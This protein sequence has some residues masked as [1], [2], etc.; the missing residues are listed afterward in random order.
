MD[1]GGPSMARVRPNGFG[2]LVDLDFLMHLKPSS[3]PI[4]ID[5]GNGNIISTNDTPYD[6]VMLI[7]NSNQEGHI[8]SKIEDLAELISLG[9]TIGGS[10][11]GAN[12]QSVM[13]NVVTMVNG[14]V[15]DVEN[16]KAW[17]T[18]MG[19][20]EIYFDGNKL[21]NIYAEKVINQLIHNI[22]N[23]CSDNNNIANTWI[24]SPEVMIRENNGQDNV[25]DRLLDAA[26]RVAFFDVNDAS[27]AK[28]E[29][30]Q[31]LESVKPNLDAI[32]DNVIEFVSEV[33]SQL[34]KLI[35][36]ELSK[37][38]GVGNSIEILKEI[39][40][41]IKIFKAEMIE[42]ISE[43]SV[44]IENLNPQ[45]Q[46]A[47]N[48]LN[49][50]NRLFFNKRNAVSNTKEDLVKLVNEMAKSNREKVRREYANRFFSS[51]QT[52]VEAYLEKVNSLKV[53]LKSISEK[54]SNQVN[55]LQNNVNEEHKTFVIELQGQYANQISITDQDIAVNQFVKTL[56][57]N[58]MF[59]FM[60]MNEVLI[61]EKMWNYARNL[62]GAL[63]W[64]NK[65]IEEVIED[66]P[67]DKMDSILQQAILKSGPLFGYNYRG[68]V[69]D[70]QLHESFFVGLP[71]S[72]GK[73]RLEKENY[74]NSFVSGTTNV[75]FTSTGIK[76]KIII[77]RQIVSVPSYSISGVEGYET[78]YKNM[79]SHHNFHIDKTWEQR[80]VR[81]N[82]SIHPDRGQDNSIELWVKGL[83]F[84][85]IKNE[86]DKYFIK[87]TSKGDPLDNFWY[88]LSQT[89]YRDDAF[90]VFK[91]N[92]IVFEVE[93]KQSIQKVRNELG[94]TKIND[95]IQ[96]VT[97]GNYVIEYSHV[98]KGIAEMKGDL[99]TFQGVLELLTKE[100]RFVENELRK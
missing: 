12:I 69:I 8:Y 67:K 62:D 88:Q 84:G 58:Q 71:N 34:A 23:A 45:L 21:G 3:P 95:K 55:F 40:N 66:I 24:D 56:D 98:N 51:L 10:E 48:S 65:N 81:E 37:L 100:V 54:A 77:Y 39:I 64:R 11:L 82:F 74:F 25:I 73:T 83:I 31:Y 57:G 27:N 20:C 63:G 4:T 36:T 16:K 30:E 60:E 6:A 41:Q 13:D 52:K 50:A 89:S 9:L 99:K 29:F 47:V 92:I 96:D 1:P 26:P 78:I 59:D 68:L 17:A 79:S 72:N 38:C 33:D 44:K 15:L 22:N 42:E 86:N 32:Q 46:S 93:L 49:D 35:K 94:D 70:K 2:A 19:I 28:P 61:R 90:D 43:F 75:D 85:F 14:G 5:Y 53:T 91:N 87:S 76:D 18:G 7:N 80:M 97:S